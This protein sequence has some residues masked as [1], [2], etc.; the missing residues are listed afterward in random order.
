[1]EGTVLRVEAEHP[2][3][4]R[5]R[6]LFRER[7]VE[8]LRELAAEAATPYMAEFRDALVLGRLVVCCNCLHFRWGADPAGIGQCERFK[9]EAFPFVPFCCSGFEPDLGF[10]P[11]LA[12]AAPE[13]LADPYGAQARLREL[14]PANPA[15]PATPGDLA[16][17]LPEGSWPKSKSSKGLSTP[18]APRYHQ[19]VADWERVRDAHR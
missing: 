2:A 17:R 10:E 7:K 1:M 16:D 3:S 15:T 13:W 5:M 11:E 14:A 8:L 4:D 19:A 18:R 9:V 12:P 6:E